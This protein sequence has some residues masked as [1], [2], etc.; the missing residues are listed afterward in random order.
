MFNRVSTEKLVSTQY[1]IK[2]TRTQKTIIID[3]KIWWKYILDPNII[4]LK[5]IVKNMQKKRDIEELV[6][7]IISSFKEI[8]ESKSIGTR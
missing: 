4:L 3:E 8:K 1:I 5:A 2:T 6:P 7:N